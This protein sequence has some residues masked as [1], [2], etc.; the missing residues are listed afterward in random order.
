MYDIVLKMQKKIIE[1]SELR[2]NKKLKPET[3]SKFSHIQIA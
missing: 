3:T 2:L 1:N